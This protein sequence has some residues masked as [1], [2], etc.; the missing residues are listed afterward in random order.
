MSSYSRGL[1]CTSF[2]LIA[3]DLGPF[4]VSGHTG[5]A[6]VCREA[7]LGRM[8]TFLGASDLQPKVVHLL[9]RPAQ[10]LLMLALMS[11]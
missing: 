2:G 6:F 3:L 8:P 4:G 10:L 11:Y 7:I 5:E 9:E 1:I